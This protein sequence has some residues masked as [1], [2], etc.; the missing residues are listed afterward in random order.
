MAIVYK[1]IAIVPNV[2]E[3]FSK[4]VYG[5][6]GFPNLQ[7]EYFPKSLL[8]FII[9]IHIV[10]T[11][12][13]LWI[14]CSGTGLLPSKVRPFTYA[15]AK[16]PLA[17]VLVRHKWGQKLDIQCSTCKIIFLL[18]LSFIVVVSDIVFLPISQQNWLKSVVTVVIVLSGMRCYF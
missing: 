2:L 11:K 12:T 8:Y 4:E 10:Y 14:R 6:P 18:C 16:L 7:C 9:L 3:R 1:M 17:T 13:I 15:L 5:I